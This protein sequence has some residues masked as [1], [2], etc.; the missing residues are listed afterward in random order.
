MGWA[1]SYVVQ[2]QIPRTDHGVLIIYTLANLNTISSSLESVQPCCS[3]CV[4]T[5]HTQTSTIVYSQVQVSNRGSLDSVLIG[6][7]L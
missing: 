2:E 3:K 4:N 7:E 5:I 1:T 6:F